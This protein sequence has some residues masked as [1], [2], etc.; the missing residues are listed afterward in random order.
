M[1]VVELNLQYR[2]ELTPL[3][4][5]KVGYVVLHHPEAVTATPEQ[6]HQWHLENGWAGAGYNEYIRKDGTVYIMRGD[7]VGAQCLYYNSVSYGICCEGDYGKEQTMPQAQ[8]DS[9]VE[10][11]RYHQSRFPNAKIVGHRELCN[12]A[13]P[14]KY[15]PL[16]QA[17][18]KLNKSPLDEAL[19]FINSKVAIDVNLWNQK[20]KDVE[21][22]DILLIK[23]ANA[24]K[25]G[26]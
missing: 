21:Y 20:S 22:L 1:N 17:I 25:E 13:C 14:G 18:D 15:F 7:N 10:R 24:W 3:N 19:E 6:I 9:L 2:N 11:L 12:T 26:K 23:I 16:Q 8:F 5:T 4:L